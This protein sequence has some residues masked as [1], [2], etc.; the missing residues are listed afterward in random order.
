MSK[1]PDLTGVSWRK[2]SFSGGSGGD[3]VEIAEGFPGLVPVRDSKDPKG[4]SL[5]FTAAA[6][7][8]FT[9]ALKHGEI[10]NT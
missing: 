7:S 10:P 6:W 8:S 5:I 3:C 2:S 4:P 1:T 9:T